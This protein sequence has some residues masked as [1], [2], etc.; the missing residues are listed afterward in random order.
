MMT[1]MTK[2]IMMTIMTKMT[3]MTMM[4]M[5]ITLMYT[6]MIISI[7]IILT[8]MITMI[9]GMIKIIIIL[10]EEKIMTIK[11]LSYKTLL[12]LFMIIHEFSE[13]SRSAEENRLL[14]NSPIKSY[15]GKEKIEI[16]KSF[17]ENKTIQPILVG[18]CSHVLQNLIK[19]HF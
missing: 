7:I 11:K 3:M 15:L 10:I 4:T 19:F 17:R 2:M 5:M 9:K 13:V 6:M 1:M 18:H 16:F 8:I 14:M 12:G